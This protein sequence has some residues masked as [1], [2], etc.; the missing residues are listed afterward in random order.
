[1]RLLHR[2]IQQSITTFDVP[3]STGT[4]AFALNNSGM[5]AGWYIASGQEHGLIRDSGGNI[6]TID[7][8]GSITTSL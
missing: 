6:T 7:P 1:M 3:G 4:Y 8:P 2:G 5:V